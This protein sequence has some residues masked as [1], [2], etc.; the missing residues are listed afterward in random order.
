MA[1]G[2]RRRGGGGEGRGECESGRRKG[3]NSLK[4]PTNSL[5][6]PSRPRTDTSTISTVTVTTHL[7]PSLRLSRR[8]F[9]ANE[10]NIRTCRDF[11]FQ[12]IDKKVVK[13]ESQKWAEEKGEA[14]SKDNQLSRKKKGKAQPLP[15]SFPPHKK[16]GFLQIKTTPIETPGLNPQNEIS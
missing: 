1:R 14:K 6:H 5:Q 3:G 10:S 12:R 13:S 2:G 16:K 15:L 9:Q 11:F 4:L 8:N 7:P